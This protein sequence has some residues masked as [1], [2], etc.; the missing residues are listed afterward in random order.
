MIGAF[1]YGRRRLRLPKARE[2][3]SDSEARVLYAISISVGLV[4]TFVYEGYT[5]AYGTGTEFTAARSWALNLSYLLFFSLVLSV[6]LRIRKTGGRHSFGWTAVVPW[7]GTTLFAFFD[8]VRTGI[9]V[10]TLIYVAACYL[11]GYRFRRRHY[12]VLGLG[13]VVFYTF[14][15]PLEVYTREYTK[16]PTMR[17]QDRIYES[18][19]TAIIEFT[20][21]ADMES[22][23][24]GFLGGADTREQYF[25]RP[26][27]Y[28]LSR[29][30]LIRADS[31][32]ISACSDGFHYGLAQIK[33]VVPGIVPRFLNKNKT[34]VPETN[35]IAN[36]S[37]LGTDV[38]AQP[39]ISAVADSYGAFGWLGVILF[40]LLGF[41]A[42]FVVY[43]SMFDLT[44]PWGTVAL[45]ICFLYFTEMSLARTATILIRQPLNF[46]VL[47]NA[48][49]LIARLFPS[50]GDS[51][52]GAAAL[53]DPGAA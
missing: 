17:L 5:A 45:G 21:R 36:V 10:P 26:G 33:E 44:R 39:V 15:S 38:A 24:T 11:R 3:V 1:L 50:R 43:E 7:L 23:I 32:L 47:S 18:I 48:V 37:G 16:L 30:S 34:Q 27:T 46:F 31:T 22:S 49:G 2:P 53:Q 14:V 40:P 42:I 29:V 6:D 19:H 13:A 51:F 41:S 20:D 9:I 4:A 12:L 25:D 35:Y 8:T 52:A 28:T